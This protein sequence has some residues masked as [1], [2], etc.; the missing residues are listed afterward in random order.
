MTLP[1]LDPDLLRAFLA[2]ADHR[3]FTRAAAQL[4][5]TQS[6][7][8]MQIRRLEM[9]VAADLFRRNTTMV[10]LTQAGE[11][12]VAYARR[13]LALNEEA[14]GK[15]REHR[16]EGR[17]RLG[18]M[19]DYG[20]H[21]LPAMLARFL[22][23]YPRI[24]IE[25]ET[26]LTSTML[27]RLGESYDLVIAM[28]AEGHEHGELLRREQ[29]VWAASAT[30]EAWLI[31]PLP[32]ALYPMGCLFRKWAIE[33]LDAVRRP[34][35]LAFVSHNLATVEAVAAQGLAVT[36]VKASFLPHSLRGLSPRDGLP[37]LPGAEIRL[38]AGPSPTRAAA[39]LAGH[40]REALAM[41]P[42]RS[43]PPR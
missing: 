37:A 7:V 34:W 12:L 18:V 6:A 29:P 11:S 42:A 20:S 19:D 21:V 41:A 25:M 14:V 15:L 39:L 30:H 8:S 5:R 17:V 32:V 35:R 27:G 2:V 1:M 33:A 16:I 4:N 23:L 26:G 28:H 24:H 43:H 9:R 22:T 10:E 3:S 38:H 31:D 36:V 13:I 40:L